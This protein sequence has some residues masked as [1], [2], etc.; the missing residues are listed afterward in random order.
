MARSVGPSLRRMISVMCGWPA[1][2]DAAAMQ[3]IGLAG[4]CCSGVDSAVL[5][6]G[7]WR[8]AEACLE[9]TQQ[10]ATGRHIDVEDGQAGFPKAFAISEGHK[11]DRK[12]EPLTI[13]RQIYLDRRS[14][15]T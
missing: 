9:A 11:K 4:S 12:S 3:A 10:P 2:P 6:I 5:Q 15:A 13:A 14:G 7:M 1:N 8:H